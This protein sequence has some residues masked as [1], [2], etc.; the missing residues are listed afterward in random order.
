MPK[1]Y[2]VQQFILGTED[3]EVQL[4]RTLRDGW[5]FLSCVSPKEN[6]ILYTFY[7]DTATGTK[8]EYV[9]KI[10]PGIKPTKKDKRK[11][12]QKIEEF[13]EANPDYV[14]EVEDIGPSVEETFFTRKECE[15]AAKQRKEEEQ[16]ALR[17]LASYERKHPPKPVKS[18][19]KDVESIAPVK[20]NSDSTPIELSSAQKAAITTFFINHNLEKIVT[21][22]P[23]R[24]GV[25]YLAEGSVKLP[26]KRFRAFME[27]GEVKFEKA[28]DVDWTATY[29]LYAEALEKS[30][31][32][33]KPTKKRYQG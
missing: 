16:R 23:R 15:D 2:K 8:R 31:I 6:V 18:K 30:R 21:L 7:K 3:I 4:N 29:K 19:N 12:G 25:E 11:K 9:E 5:E 20:V 1:Q 33:R 17:A 27:N 32:Q 22:Q 28:Y 13:L 10:N 14:G 24:P 26:N